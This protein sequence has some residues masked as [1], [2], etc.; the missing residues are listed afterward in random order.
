M[1]K[2]IVK[3]GDL[4]KAASEGMDEFVD[5]FVKAIYDAIGG[6]LTAENMAELNADQITLLAYIMLRDEMMDG[7]MVQLIHNGY[8]A[9]FFK[10]PF[11]KAVKQWEMKDLSK[12][13]YNAYR[14]TGCT[15]RRLSAN[16]A[17]RSLLRYTNSFRNS[18]T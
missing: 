12:L 10:N 6:T 17:T 9:F 1:I 5:V 18:T 15:K 11:A 14:Y 7:G 13:I 8:G 4:R 16:A 3:D 2:V